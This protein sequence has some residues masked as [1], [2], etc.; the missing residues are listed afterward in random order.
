MSEILKGRKILWNKKISQVN[1]GKN[2]PMFGRHHSEETRN[3]IRQSLLGRVSPTL[4]K[5]FSEETRKKIGLAN[6]GKHH[7]EEAKRKVRMARLN[8][9]FPIIDTKLELKLQDSLRNRNILFQTHK[10]IHGQPDIFVEPNICIF[11]DGCYWHG[12]LLC[13]SK[14]IRPDRVK[15]RLRDEKISVTLNE[16]GYKVF[17]F[18]EHDIKNDFDRVIDIIKNALPASIRHTV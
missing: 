7:T 5:H 6:K 8:Q 9:I 12:C 16:M 3:K 13:F 4:G 1:S 10:P 15:Q 18:Y 11:V 2:N 14:G 17:R